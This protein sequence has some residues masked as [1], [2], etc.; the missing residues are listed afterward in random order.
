MPAPVRAGPGAPTGPAAAA[1]RGTAWPRVTCSSISIAA[2][3]ILPGP[4]AVVGC[5]SASSYHDSRGQPLA[6]KG[7]LTGSLSGGDLWLGYALRE[8]RRD[9]R[10]EVVG[11]AE[12]GQLL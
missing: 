4:P 9:Q 7:P 8:Q 12:G 2:S 6:M 10:I 11:E 3:R 5:H 1:A